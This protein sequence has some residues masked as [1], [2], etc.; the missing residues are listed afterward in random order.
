MTQTLAEALDAAE[1]RRYQNGSWVPGCGGTEQPMTVNGVRVL[2]C[3]H[4][5]TGEHAYM[6]LDTDMIMTDAEF[7]ALRGW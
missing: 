4:T 6:N 1:A 3:W 2:Y 5:G 7:D